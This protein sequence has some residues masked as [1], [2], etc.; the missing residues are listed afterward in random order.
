MKT[1]V[2]SAFNLIMVAVILAFTGCNDE[3]SE[4]TLVAEPVYMSYDD[5][6]ASVK[7]DVPEEISEPGKIYFK[8]SYIF[9][10]EIR[11]GIHVIDNSNPASPKKIAFINIPGNVDMAIKANMLFVDSYVDLVALDISDMSNIKEKARVKN[12]FPYLLS[13]LPE[14]IICQTNEVNNNLGVVVNWEVKKVSREG[15]NGN[16]N[17]QQM[18]FYEASG[19]KDFIGLAGARNASVNSG[20]GPTGI[21]GSM[22]R[23]TI[24]EDILYMVDQST[25][26]ILD[27]SSLTNPTLLAEK[28]IGWNIETLFLYNNKLF[29]GT[30]TGMIIYSVEAPSSPVFL[31]QYSHFKSCDPVVVEG[32]KAYVTLR[33]GNRC[34]DLESRLDI[35]DISNVASPKLLSS[36]LLT[37]PFGLGIDKS[38]LF[39]CDGSA[40]LK[41]FNASDPLKIAENKLAEFKNI[42]TYDV[43]PVNGILILIG[44]DGFYEYDY[45]NLKD[46]KQLSHI[47]IK[48]K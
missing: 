21:G 18:R 14:D 13:P 17:A 2:L 4:K 23:F 12:I 44:K 16:S 34:G 15:L 32:D 42:N 19:S 9:I 37:E 5:L 6:R 20:G 47:S 26:R 35:L 1:K 31:S 43:I 28:S 11:K 25:L 38:T 46:I 41:V 27:I 7:I 22:A 33:G 8:D 39:V 24:N 30:Q 45:T 36:T 48:A 10:N 3:I 29:F 40:G